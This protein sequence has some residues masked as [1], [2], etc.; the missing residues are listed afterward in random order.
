MDE[1]CSTTR[2]RSP[3]AYASCAEVAVL[4]KSPLSGNDALAREIRSVVDHAR[5]IDDHETALALALV[6]E[7]VRNS[8]V[9]GLCATVVRETITSKI[10]SSS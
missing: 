2:A 5:R 1:Q 4:P 3:A 10:H 9:T 6:L 7:T 8:T